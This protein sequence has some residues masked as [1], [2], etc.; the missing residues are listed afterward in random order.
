[1]YRQYENPY[2]LE[3]ELKEVQEA[4]A[5]A[6]DAGE[7]ELAISLGEREYELK[8]RVRFAWDDDE[9]ECYGY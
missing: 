6:F 2:T 7:W 4:L 9:A 8:E 5:A 3:Q 1:M